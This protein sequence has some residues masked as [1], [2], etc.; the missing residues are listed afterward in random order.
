M[1]LIVRHTEICTAE[2]LVV[3]P[4]PSFLLKLRLLLKSCKIYEL[5]PTEQISAEFIQGEAKII[6]L[7]PVNLLLLFGIKNNC[8]SNGT[9]E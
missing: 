3:L 6:F 5:R 9:E 2:P 1:V 4:E 7:R 8:N